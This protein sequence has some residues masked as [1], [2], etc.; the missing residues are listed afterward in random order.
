MPVLKIMPRLMLNTR[1]CFVAAFELALG[2]ST[3][4]HLEGHLEALGSSGLQ[5]LAARGLGMRLVK[6]SLEK[7]KGLPPLPHQPQL[8]AFCGISRAQAASSGESTEGQSEQDS[9][10]GLLLEPSF[11]LLDRT[12]QRTEPICRR[13]TREWR[14]IKRGCPMRPLVHMSCKRKN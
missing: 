4:N 11:T 10:V 12:I 9:T 3:L 2:D 1:S 14:G 7:K 8:F 5:L 6:P 13:L